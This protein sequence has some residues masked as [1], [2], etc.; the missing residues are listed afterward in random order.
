M[1]TVTFHRKAIASS[2]P[3]HEVET[4]PV[5]PLGLLEND[6]ACTP[7]AQAVDPEFLERFHRSIE[8]MLSDVQFDG[9][10]ILNEASWRPLVSSLTILEVLLAMRQFETA[11]Q[12]GEELFANYPMDHR[13]QDSLFRSKYYRLKGRVSMQPGRELAGNFCPMLWNS[14]HVLPQGG[15]YSC[16]SVWLRTPVGNAFSDSVEDI[17]HGEMA[18]TVRQSAI[19]G[20]YRYCGKIS[21]PHIQ[22][23]A[24]DDGKLASDFWLKEEPAL[25]AGPTRFNLSYDMS[26]NLSC[27]SCRPE[28]IVAKGK[29]LEVIEHATDRIMD[30]LRDAERMEVTGSGDPFAS[31]SF[32]RLLQKINPV[33]F[34]KLRITIMS[35]GLL[36]RRKEWSKFSHLHGMID[37]V[38]ISVDAVKPETYRVL[39]RGGELSDLIPNL[40][41]IGELRKNLDIARYRL[42]FVV[43]QLNYKEM[44]AFHELA[45]EVG[46]DEVHFQ[47]L[48]DWGTMPPQQLQN[49]RIHLASHPDFP[50]FV[51]QL[52]ALPQDGVPRVQSDFSYLI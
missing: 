41:F 42:C 44:G 1:Q 26:C 39:R 34:P 35:N 28:P 12:L 15:V 11:V 29:T 24:F 3:L 50:D 36:M 4:L 5:D 45:R 51:E 23:A 27:P 9:N 40:H 2:K 8:G 31:K 25:P 10:T 48:H 14:M 46:A 52:K 37:A 19:D 30:S 49:Q 33:D 38:N 22:R 16:C 13:V 6:I 43:Q 7:T 21:C 47:M 20:D 32:R 18:T 17:W